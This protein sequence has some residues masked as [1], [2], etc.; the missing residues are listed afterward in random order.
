MFTARKLAEIPG[1]NPW[2][3][4][5]TQKKNISRV[6]LLRQHDRQLLRQMFVRQ[7]HWCFQR[8]DISKKVH[9][10]ILIHVLSWNIYFRLLRKNTIWKSTIIWRNNWHYII[11]R[12]RRTRLL[13][14]KLPIFVQLKKKAVSISIG[15]IP[16]QNSNTR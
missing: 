16:D 15:E 10:G 14:T 8:S 2:T 3:F 11:W 4:S 9:F 7:K 1:P 13:D 12:S 6:L 5:N